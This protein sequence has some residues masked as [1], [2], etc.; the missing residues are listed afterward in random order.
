[1]ERYHLQFVWYCC[2]CVYNKPQE[3]REGSFTGICQPS[4]MRLICQ[5]KPAVPSFTPQCHT[6]EGICFFP[7]ITT[8]QAFTQGCR[9]NAGPL[10]TKLSSGFKVPY[11]RAR[12]IFKGDDCRIKQN[13]NPCETHTATV[14]LTAVS[15]QLDTRCWCSAYCCCQVKT[16]YFQNVKFQ[17]NIKKINL[18]SCMTCLFKL[19]LKG[20]QKP[21]G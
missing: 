5:F 15:L 1:M 16:F 14:A 3:D 20:L 11:L 18:V 12:S 7:P 4:I 2:G 17:K 8:S 9:L 21:R 6:E 10:I 13:I 19:I